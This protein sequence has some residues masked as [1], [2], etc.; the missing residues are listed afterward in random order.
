MK[1]KEIGEKQER[2]NEHGTTDRIVSQR[3]R[4]KWRPALI[5]QPTDVFE[6][7]TPLRP[8]T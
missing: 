2:E 6:N 1:V 8:S 4:Q 7:R 5:L 3:M